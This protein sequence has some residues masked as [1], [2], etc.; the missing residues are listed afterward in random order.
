MKTL[1]IPFFCLFICCVTSLNIFGQENTYSSPDYFYSNLFNDGSL[2][3]FSQRDTTTS[4]Q[5]I[6]I[7]STSPL[8]GSGSLRSVNRSTPYVNAITGTLLTSG[9]NLADGNRYEF[10]FL[11][12]YTSSDA[13]GS[14]V[15]D[16]SPSGLGNNKGGWRFWINASSKTPSSDNSAK[17]LYFCQVGKSLQFY[18]KE[19]QWYTRSVFSYDLDPGKTYIIKLVVESGRYRLFIDPYYVY[20]NKSTQRGGDVNFNEGL[21]SYSFTVL[22]MDERR[23]SQN[24]QFD[25]LKIYRPTIKLTSNAALN[26]NAVG[27]SNPNIAQ[28]QKDIIALGYSIEARGI[29]NLTSLSF[30]LSNGN[31]STFFSSIRVYRSYDNSFSVTADTLVYTITP[32]GSSNLTYSTSMELYAAPV[33]STPVYYFIVFDLRTDFDY[34]I[35]ETNSLRLQN[36][37]IKYNDN[38][39]GNK[40]LTTNYSGQ[41]F[42]AYLAYK[43]LGNTSDWNTNT[44][45]YYDTYRYYSPY[46]PVG[47]PATAPPNGSYV[48]IPS[49]ATTSP[50]ATADLS[51]AG[52]N[53]QTG[54]TLTLNNASLTVTKEMTGDGSLAFTGNTSKSLTLSSGVT[55]TITNL[56]IDKGALNKSLTLTSGNAMLNVT[57]TITVTKGTLKVNSNTLTLKSSAAGT[58]SVAKIDITKAAITGPVAVER[59]VTG[60]GGYNQTRSN[61]TTRNYRILSSPVWTDV[62]SGNN[63]STLSYMATSAIVTGATGGYTSTGNA[64]IYL[65]NENFAGTSSSFSSSN[66][67]PVTDISGPALTV[68]GAANYLYPGTGFLFYYRGDKINN[69]SAKTAPPY[70]APESV[71]F[72]NTGTINQGPIAIKDFYGNTTWTKHTTASPAFQGLTLVGNPYPSAIDWEKTVGFDT[73]GKISNTIWGFNYITNQYEAYTRATGGATNGNIIMSGQAFFVKNTGADGSTAS[74]TINEDAKTSSQTTLSSNLLLGLPKGSELPISRIKLQLYL[75]ALNYDNVLIALRDGADEKFNEQEDGVDIGGSGAYESMSVLSSDEVYLANNAIPYPTQQAK[76]VPVYVSATSSGIYQIKKTGIEN[77]PKLYDVWL[78]D[79]FT[80]DSLDLRANQ[81]YNFNIDK[82][83][84][85]TFGKDRFKVVIRQNPAMALKLL[86]F[87]ASKVTTGVQLA[88]TTENESNYTNFTIERSTDGGKNFEIIGSLHSSDLGKYVLIDKAP[89]KGLNQY[90]LK[91]DDING[92]ISYSDIVKV[93]YAYKSDNALATISVYPNPTASTINVAIPSNNN[94]TSYSIRVTNGTG[95]IVKSVTTNNS[96]WQGNVSDLM[97]GTYFVQITDNSTRAT[98]G[99]SKFI[100]L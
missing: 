29:Y 88:W 8:S 57:G 25:D 17:G 34:N 13:N 75:D 20:S 76:T 11:Y 5:S 27:I 14:D 71:V 93:M 7:S 53:I 84:P 69:L 82:A 33:T 19:S 2:H 77:L 38:N 18:S 35:N 31:M 96:N 55:T 85:A 87:D 32:P 89:V 65:Y 9:T 58:A 4:H 60:G 49:T 22:E 50:I 36:I 81:T 94:A 40:T 95:T 56:N 98:I 3:S 52:L 91:Q 97:P 1:L 10:D 41:Q 43:W 86:G 48:L 78:M 44:N 80:K 92:T 100:K 64:T 74:L 37:S 46:G 45:W 90:R 62:V 23:A 28:G 24:F 83:N 63:V 67:R 79:S 72:S 47:T 66:F 39:G 99:N 73:T 15:T 21:S 51:V 42:T 68:G 6:Q 54:K 16:F 26:T 12:K 30:D 70:V 59:Y 61:Y